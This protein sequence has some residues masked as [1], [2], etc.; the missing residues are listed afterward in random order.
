ML[1]KF[2]IFLFLDILINI[3]C[4]NNCENI[5]I[6]KNNIKTNS[7][8]YTILEVEK[9][10]NETINDEK[11]F[12]FK[13][14]NYNN[15]LLV[16]FFSINCD[17]QIFINDTYDFEKINNIR[18]N[19]S[20]SIRIKLDEIENTTI[21][22]LHLNYDNNPFRTCPLVINTIYEENSTL[23]YEGNE[24]TIL[25]FDKYLKEI[26]LSYNYTN[27]S[28]VTF[29]F[30]FNDIASFDIIYSYNDENKTKSISNSNN[31]FLYDLPE[32]NKKHPSLHSSVFLY[33]N[34]NFLIVPIYS[35]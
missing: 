21:K 20:F 29:S 14:E 27:Y 4:L 35:K 31:I 25:F 19:D 28:F 17:I 7:T 1:I 13:N 8:N 11:I 2:I 33:S 3:N 9:I 23:K 26:E 15:N 24:P 22:V 12:I 5:N 30:I 34:F 6:F 10:I 32:I 16:N 18:N